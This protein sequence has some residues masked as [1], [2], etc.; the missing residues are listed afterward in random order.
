MS[1][2]T[3]QLIGCPR[4]RVIIPP[5]DDITTGTN[6]IKEQTQEVCMNYIDI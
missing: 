6:S 5:T 3:T 1:V 4:E 2:R